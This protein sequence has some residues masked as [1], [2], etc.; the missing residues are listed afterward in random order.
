MEY[1]Q[2]GRTNLSVSEIGLGTAQL[3]GPSQIDG[4]YIGSPRIKKEEALL[5]LNKAFESGI[6][7]Y[8]SSDKYGDGAAERL[9]GQAFS[10]KRDRVILATKCGITSTGDRCFEKQYVKNCLEQSLKNLKTDYLDVF[11]LTKP[12]LELIKSGEIYETLDELKKAGKIRFS[13]VSTGSDE[14]TEQ[15]VTDNQVDS[16][17]IFYNLLHIKPN[18]LLIK[19]AFDSGLGLIIRSPLSS[20]MLTGKYDY[21]TKFNKEDDRSVYLFGKTLKKRVDTVNKIIN[22]FSLTDQYNI[23]H[24]SLNYLL[25]NDKISAIIPGVS[26]VSQLIDILKLEDIKRLSLSEFNELEDFVRTN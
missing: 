2:L 17:Q 12:S 26:K 15:L 16:L 10:K 5:I 23:L 1:R 21:K 6:N 7:F 13:G 4:K 19:K 18:E 14:E 22:H 20:G 25:S 8:D 24:L 9:L 11:Q 3:G